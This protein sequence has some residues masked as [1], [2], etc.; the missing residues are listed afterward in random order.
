MLTLPRVLHFPAGDRRFSL[1]IE[2]VGE[3]AEIRAVDPVPG[4]PA[5][6][7]GLAE[8]RG[9]IVTLLSL[10]GPTAPAA[11]APPAPLSPFDAPV[12]A[13]LLAGPLA[14]LGV[15]VRGRAGEIEISRQVPDEPN[16]AVPR[17]LPVGPGPRPFARAIRL[18]DG[19]SAL[20]IN[21]EDLAEYATGQI[22]ERVRVAERG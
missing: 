10:A 6:V 11:S 9:R 4:A 2:A 19:R 20:L 17:D 22:R 7:A 12:I 18:E 14:H 21:P 15:V 13:V 8:F 3:I 1:P 5:A 16:A